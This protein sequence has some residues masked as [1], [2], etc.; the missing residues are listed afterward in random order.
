MEVENK[1]QSLLLR[2]IGSYPGPLSLL[3]WRHSFPFYTWRSKT[4]NCDINTYIQH[5]YHYV[6][7]RLPLLIYTIILK[8]SKKHSKKANNRQTGN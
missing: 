7:V 6:D 1:H 8:H 3:S 4:L 2:R 5:P